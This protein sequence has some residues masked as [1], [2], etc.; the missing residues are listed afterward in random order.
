MLGSDVGTKK[1][2]ICIEK[3][4]IQSANYVKRHESHWNICCMHV[5]S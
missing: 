2:E 3:K 1:G 5:K 4:K